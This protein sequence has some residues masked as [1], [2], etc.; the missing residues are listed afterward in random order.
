MSTKLFTANVQPSTTIFHI[1]A[2]SNNSNLH[3]YGDWKMSE[4][5]SQA[6][7]S[8]WIRERDHIIFIF[9]WG[10][11]YGVYVVFLK[12]IYLLSGK[13]KISSPFWVAK[14]PCHSLIH[15]KTWV[16]IGQSSGS[17]KQGGGLGMDAE[18][19]K[20]ERKICVNNEPHLFGREQIFAFNFV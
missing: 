16:S 3:V 11:C 18:Q 19:G 13:M 7:L 6:I 15:T 12:V 9:R 5:L 4:A 20:E 1:F 14:C 10:N 17:R 8:Y 2:D